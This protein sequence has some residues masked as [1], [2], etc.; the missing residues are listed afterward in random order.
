MDADAKNVG[1]H[2]ELPDSPVGELLRRARWLAEIDQIF[3]DWVPA[4]IARAM[5]VANFRDGIIVIYV[6]SAAALTQLRYSEQELLQVLTQ[7]LKPP[8][9]KLEIKIKGV[10]PRS[11]SA[12]V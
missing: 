2:L 6:D 11:P 10:P 1:A 5:R 12:R 3:R 7:R 9:K 4:P 8:C